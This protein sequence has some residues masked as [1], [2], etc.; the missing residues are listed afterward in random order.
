MKNDY[1]QKKRITIILLAVVAVCL[2]GG[3]FWYMGTLGSTQPPV[4]LAENQ[5]ETEPTVTIPES[6]PDRTSKPET[7][8]EPETATEPETSSE[9]ET[10]GEPETA[11]RQEKESSRAAGTVTGA[12]RG[13]PSAVIR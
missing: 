2:A 10:T 4:A 11:A 9:P 13:K 3:L 7:V 8:S 5:T 1:N 12:V 6:Q